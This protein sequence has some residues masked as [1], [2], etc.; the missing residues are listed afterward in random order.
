[1]IGNFVNLGTYWQFTN[2]AWDWIIQNKKK[3]RRRRRR[4]RKKN[5]NWIKSPVGYPNSYFYD[6]I[7]NI[8]L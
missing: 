2:A 6:K 5:Q 3:G 7:S 4:K 8:L 1:M